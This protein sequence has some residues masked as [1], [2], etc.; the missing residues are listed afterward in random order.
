MTATDTIMVSPMFTTTYT[1]SVADSC[2][3]FKNENVVVTIVC[4]ILIPNVFTPNGDG[5]NDFFMVENLEFYPNSRIEIFNRWGR[6]VYQNDN[7]QNDWNGGDCAD[8]TYYYILF[9]PNGTSYSGF[10]TILR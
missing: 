3:N 1:I 10:L 7:Y 5:S 4:P 2:G 6:K 9:M 8:G